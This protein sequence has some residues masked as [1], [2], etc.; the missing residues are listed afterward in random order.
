[1][2]DTKVSDLNSI[3]V[4]GNNDILY[5]VN[6]TAGTSN[7]ITYQNLLSG[8]NDS[9]TTLTTDVNSFTTKVLELSSNFESANI[10]VGPLTTDILTISGDVITLSAEFNSRPAGVTDSFVIASSTFTFLGGQLTS[11]TL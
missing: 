3:T 4:A 8:V 9:I 2:A 11:V 5:I 10:D 7:K 6:P 1:M